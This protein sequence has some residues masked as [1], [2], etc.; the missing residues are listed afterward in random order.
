GGPPQESAR[1]GWNPTTSRRRI[2]RAS[3]SS[4]SNGGRRSCR[5]PSPLADYGII[6]PTALGAHHASASRRNQD[7]AVPE[8]TPAGGR[9]GDATDRRWA[10]GSRLDV[11]AVPRDD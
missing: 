1:D 10:T 3:V 11:M 5:R 7:Q 4:G 8:M 6:P 2:G 9:R